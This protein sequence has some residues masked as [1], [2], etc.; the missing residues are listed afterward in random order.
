M[1]ENIIQPNYPKAALGL[2]QESVTAIALQ[3]AGKGR[4]GIKQAATIELPPHLLQ[5]SFIEQNIKS[6]AE[7]TVLLQEA[8]SNA[9]LLK[10]KRWSVS[11]PS[12]TARTAI[13][14]LD[15]EPASK[16]ELAQVLDW[17]AENTFGIPAGEMRISREKISADASGK[18]RYFAT[19]VKLSV[20]DEYETLFEML[21]WQTGL[22]LPRAVSEANWL[23]DKNKNRAKSDSLLISAQPDGFVALVMR[24]GEPVVVRSV[25][26]TANERDDEIYRLLMFYRDRLGNDE[27]ENFLE[28]LLVVGKNL[29]P[30]R[31]KEI[32]SEALGRTLN[33]LQPE[34]VG[35]NMPGQTLNFD[36]IA[37]PAGLAALGWK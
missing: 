23:F 20:I 24:G 8:V 1:L 13:L 10:Q 17:K 15:T 36:E 4:F 12:N 19:A 37:A 16:D 30:D 6:P 14:T 35:L 7:M 5:P 32:A 11:L 33:I 26:C 34:D 22:I 3:R 28:K 31:L 9:G 18:A 27:S 25:T 2:E 21:G 29:T